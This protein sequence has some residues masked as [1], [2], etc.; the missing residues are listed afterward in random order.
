MCTLDA[1]IQCSYRTRGAWHPP[2]G[3]AEM[4]GAINR[5]SKFEW[6]L[7]GMRPDQPVDGPRLPDPFPM[8]PGR[9]MPAPKTIF[10]KMLDRELGPTAVLVRFPTT[11]CPLDQLEFCP[12]PVHLVRDD[13]LDKGGDWS[14]STLVSCFAESHGVPGEQIR[15][16]R[17][18]SYYMPAGCIPAVHLFMEVLNGSHFSVS[19]PC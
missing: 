7:G 2:R 16:R 4:P 15:T 1:L 11:M 10:F 9:T 6:S 19:P 3:T 5:L 12:W 18:L 14:L 17:S 13:A 8:G